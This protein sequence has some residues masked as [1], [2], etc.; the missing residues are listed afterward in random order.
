MGTRGRRG[1]LSG[2]SSGPALTRHVE[3]LLRRSSW[4]QAPSQV[5]AQQPE[6][7]GPS[8]AGA[9]RA[10]P[11]HVLWKGGRGGPFVSCW[12]LRAAQRHHSQPPWPHARLCS[13]PHL[14]AG[15]GAARAGR[16]GRAGEGVRDHAPEDRWVDTSEA[17]GGRCP[18]LAGGLLGQ[19]HHGAQRKSS[20]G[21]GW[22]AR[23]MC[24]DPRQGPAPPLS[25]IPGLQLR[26]GASAPGLSVAASLTSRSACAH[27]PTFLPAPHQLFPQATEPEKGVAWPQVLRQAGKLLRRRQTNEKRGPP[28]PPPFLPRTN[29]LPPGGPREI[30]LSP[31]RAAAKLSTHESVSI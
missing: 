12:S 26:A 31:S 2:C 9:V 3:Q 18:A 15:A 17:S 24:A 14:R 27:P 10:R 22:G 13:G 16:V 5:P 7:Q 25:L 19:V 4:Q 29:E 21:R 20:S 30:C 28:H 11:A 23:G 1:S 6:A 8:G